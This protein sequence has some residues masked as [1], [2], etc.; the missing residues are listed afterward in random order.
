MLAR[1]T[2]GAVAHGEYPAL[3]AN[4]NRVDGTDSDEGG[5]VLARFDRA[6]IELMITD[7]DRVYADTNPR[8]DPMR[9][10]FAVLYR[11]ADVV[12]VSFEHDNGAGIRPVE[13]DR[14]CPDAAGHDGIGACLWPW[15]IS[16]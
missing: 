5:D 10:E 16:D 14:V 2:A 9:G 6:T 4:G 12:V 1:V 13:I 8:T 11:D 15:L 7:L 3:V